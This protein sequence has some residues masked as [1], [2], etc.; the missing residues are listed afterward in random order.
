M[1]FK[2]SWSFK[3]FKCHSNWKEVHVFFIIWNIECLWLQSCSEY[4]SVSVITKRDNSQFTPYYIRRIL[5]NTKILHV[6]LIEICCDKSV[7]LIIRTGRHS[8]IRTLPLMSFRELNS[9]SG[10]I[11]NIANLI[12]L[13]YIDILQILLH[14]KYFCCSMFVVSFHHFG[15]HV[16]NGNRQK[17][18]HWRTKCQSHRKL[19]QHS[20]NTRISQNWVTWQK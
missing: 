2:L 18:S 11:C 9:K 16:A 6:T 14:P 17:D 5:Y 19:K 15:Y 13:S 3:Y 1:H 12:K 8:T 20:N 4:L 7:W 10:I